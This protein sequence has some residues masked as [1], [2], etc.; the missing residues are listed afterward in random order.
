MTRSSTAAFALLTALWA[1]G[2]T[3]VG[4][5]ELEPPRP[6]SP[7]REPAPETRAVPETVPETGALPGS[8]AERI[9]AGVVQVALEAIGTP[10]V[11]GGTDANGF[12]CSGLIQYAYAQY[13][14]QLPRVSR[15]QVRQGRSVLLRPEHL[16]PGDVLGFSLDRPGEV[17]HVGLYIGSNEFIHSGSDGVKIANIL[18]PYWQ[19]HLVAAR[20]LVP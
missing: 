1:G 8:E 9:T 4:S 13:G 17:S 14:I 5:S 19:E 3:M 2:C 15:D 20:R 10:Y 6:A 7:D 12:D 18:S 16:R 11:W